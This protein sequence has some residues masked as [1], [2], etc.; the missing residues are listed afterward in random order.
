MPVP[1]RAAVAAGSAGKGAAMSELALRSLIAHAVVDRTLC[2]RLL[3]GERQQVLAL[4][5]LDD[6]ERAVLSTFKGESLQ[7]FAAQLEGWM[8]DQDGYISAPYS[9][10][11]TALR[12]R[13]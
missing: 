11:P 9:G 6:Q 12:G 5:D 2:K 7:T 10:K 3:N 8:Q 4:F 13:W 1:H